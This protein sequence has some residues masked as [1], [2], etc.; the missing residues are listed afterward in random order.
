MKLAACFI[1]WC[2][3]AMLA[4]AQPGEV[5]I[6]ENENYFEHQDIE[7]ALKNPDRKSWMYYR[8]YSRSTG[9][10]EHSC[11][12]AEVAENQPQDN[13]YEFK[14]GYKVGEEVKE[15]TLFARP[16]KTE[17]TDRTT[18]NAMRVTRNKDDP[19]GQN[20]RLIYSNYKDCDILRV[21]GTD[22][23]F[24][25]ECE[26][27]VHDKAVDGGVPS[28]C[29]SVYGNACGKNH[30]SF[31]RQVFNDSCKE[32]VNETLQT[33]PATP[34]APEEIP[35]ES[36]AATPTMDEDKTSTSTAAP[37]C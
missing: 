13:V 8:T 10:T 5:R 2:F 30:Q 14:Q 12:Y 26:L 35:E 11:V 34:P 32:R 23:N 18:N 33:T 17:H 31:K 4:N 22:K 20:Y 15:H 9:S 21:M 36:T 16:Y 6:D 28:A 3:F 27:Y 7:K 25:H 37:G 1:Q 29:M 19:N 24:G